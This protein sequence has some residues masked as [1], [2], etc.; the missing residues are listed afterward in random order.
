VI[1]N[2]KHTAALDDLRASYENA[3]A[4]IETDTQRWRDDFD[5]KVIECVQVSILNAEMLDLVNDI[6]ADLSLP[7]LLQERVDELVARCRAVLA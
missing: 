1:T 2:K 3:I 4:L 6:V 5:R 7:S